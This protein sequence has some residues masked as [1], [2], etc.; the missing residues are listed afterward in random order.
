[1]EL[2]SLDLEKALKYRLF[3]S[4]R[5]L[6]M[7]LSI[8]LGIFNDNLIRSGLVVLITYA[9]KHDIELT[10][11]PEI[12][13]TICYALLVTPMVLFSSLAGEI[14]DKY[15]KSRL[16][17]LTKVAE[18]FIILAAAYGFYH[19]DIG[20]LM[21][22]LF[23][24]GTHSAFNIPIKF[25]ILPQ[26]LKRE[27]LLVGN[28]FIASGSYLAILIGMI[29]GGIIVES[30]GNLIGTVAIIVAITGFIASLFVPPAPSAHQHMN[31][32]FN[33]WKGSCSI[34]CHAFRD[35][36]L[37]RT[38][39][40]LSWFITVG[41]I[42]I[43]QFANYARGVIH[44]DNEVYILFLTVF[45]VGIAIG[46]LLC[47]TLLKSQISTRFTPFATM[48]I[49]IFTMLMIYFTPTAPETG[50]L[51]NISEFFSVT[52]HLLVVGCMLLVAICGGLYIV[53]LYA[54]LQSRTTPTH[55][56]QIIAASNLSDSIA[57][58]ISAIISAALLSY[59]LGVKDLFIIV[60][61]ITLGVSWY[62]RKI[63]A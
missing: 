9:S 1:M 52:S 35:E 12:L 7:F 38:I 8:C 51:M 34:I 10:M 43:A 27:E 23:V 55:R 33:L 22:V 44:A 45:S 11:Q 47:D 13:V 54:L 29:V 50:E 57:M 30:P 39:I 15:E 36:T 31:I 61:F 17:V 58:T 20:L 49:A 14:A 37:K 41:S 25:S 5:F 56:S 3:T 24:S 48:G 19:N 40:A 18:I 2:E 28:G 21:I 53:P 59:G 62:V 42:Y 60:A 4:R 26:H 16:I 46:S 6:P 63:V 32:S